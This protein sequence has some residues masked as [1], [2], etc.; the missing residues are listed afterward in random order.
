MCGH[1]SPAMSVEEVRSILGADR[2]L[3]KKLSAWFGSCF[4]RLQLTSKMVV[5]KKKS[6]NDR[7]VRKKNGKL[8][9][10]KWSLNLFFQTYVAIG[11][12][13]WSKKWSLNLFCQTYVAIGHQ[14]R[15]KMVAQLLLPNIRRNRASKKWPR[16]P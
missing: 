14:K 13:K 2:R 7:K 4:R 6:Q 12:Q 9:W 1:L 15:S 16:G 5:A 11:H 3:T 10:Q 8:L